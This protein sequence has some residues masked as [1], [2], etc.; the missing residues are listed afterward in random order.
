MWTNLKP[1]PNLSIP[2]WKQADGEALGVEE[3]DQ[4]QLPSLL[5]LKYHAISDAADKLGG[6]EEIK[7]ICVQI[8]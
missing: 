7:N 3:V 6:A 5:Q 1:E 8:M 4:E 2:S